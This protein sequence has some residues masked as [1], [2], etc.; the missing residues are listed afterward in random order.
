M[1]HAEKLTT[2]PDLDA[3]AE[4]VARFPGDAAGRL[5]AVH[6]ADE[7]G[8]C[9]GCWSQNGGARWPC[10]PYLIGARVQALP[11]LSASGVD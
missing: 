1:S 8:R 2:G 3:L 11:N 5:I 4:Q 6:Q 7:Q 10:T 9:R